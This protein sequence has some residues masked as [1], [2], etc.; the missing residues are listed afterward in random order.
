MSGMEKRG[1][2][3]GREQG[4]V[5]SVELT[6]SR[7]FL[8][9]DWK[10][11]LPS[12]MLLLVLYTL[13]GIPMGLSGSIPFLLLEKVSYSEQAIFSLVSIPFSMKLLWAPLV[14][15][16]RFYALPRRLLG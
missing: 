9:S 1:Q 3:G 4:D 12:I 14:R 7:E 13:Q 16:N 8:E 10:K 2:N 11:D 15:I 6:D 5:E